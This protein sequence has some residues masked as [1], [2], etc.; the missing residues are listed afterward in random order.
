MKPRAHVVRAFSLIEAIIAIV[1]LSVAIPA[2]FWAV[3]DAA[4][5]RVEPVMLNRARW[6][7]AEKIED[8]L[9]D[10]ANSGRGY[11]Y[12][13]AENY[14]E[15]SPVAGFAGFSRQ[16]TIVERG[17]DLVGPGTGYKV[18]TVRVN[19]SGARGAA[20]TFELAAVVTDS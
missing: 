19:Y 12:V 8:V 14:P 13:V 2:M 18:V 7:A 11:G 9:A 3:R 17:P 6:L 4:E 5:R 10:R 1:I 16:V 15:E 20:R